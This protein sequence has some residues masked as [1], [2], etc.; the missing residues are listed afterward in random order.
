MRD[1]RQSSLTAS[2]R[3]TFADVLVHAH[4]S[5][6]DRSSRRERPIR[7][8]RVG[9]RW[10]KA[11][12]R[13]VLTVAISFVSYLTVAN[14]A[15][16]TRLLRDAVSGASLSFAIS[17]DVTD[18]RLDYVSA[19]LDLPRPRSRRRADDSRPRPSRRVALDAR[20]RRCAHLS[21]RPTPSHVPRDTGSIER[22]LAP[23][24][25]A[26]RSGECDPGGRLGASAH[27]RLQRSA[28][29]GR[30]ARSAAAD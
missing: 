3:G 30:G 7:P 21:R 20:P 12:E 5:T 10:Q 26:A 1:P 16:R 25:I 23:R 29:L 22:I 4:S 6:A 27:R 2:K 11:I 19:Y 28:A 24:E 14:L 15:L 17:G 13:L 8:S 9:I 18:L